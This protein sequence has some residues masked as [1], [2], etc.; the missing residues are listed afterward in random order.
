M[1][2]AWAIKGPDGKILAETVEL[3]DENAWCLILFGSEYRTRGE[4]ENAGYTCVPVT[5]TEGGAEPVGEWT[6]CGNIL[7][8]AD[9][10]Y[11]VKITI[12]GNWPDDRH[13]AT[14]IHRVAK[15]LNAPPADESRALLEEVLDI[16]NDE[17]GIET[18]ADVQRRIEKFL[19]RSGK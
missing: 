17:G 4:M 8:N 10:T 3:S 16:L 7:M 11:D 13:R 18:T 6:A 15:Q 19:A 5:I 14:F 12:D 9:D 2:Q 1:T